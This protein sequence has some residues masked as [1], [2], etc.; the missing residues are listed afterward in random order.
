[1]AAFSAVFAIVR[2]VVAVARAARLALRSS[3]GKASICG[4]KGGL[5]EAAMMMA[6]PPGA[7]VGVD[8]ARK[9]AGVRVD[10]GTRG[11]EQN[12]REKQGKTHQNE[13]PTWKPWLD[14]TSTTPP[15]AAAA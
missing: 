14:S 2:Q 4:R 10:V 8:V 15:N 3:Q 13:P 7:A 6:G 5:G 11:E 9:G 1:M 12:G